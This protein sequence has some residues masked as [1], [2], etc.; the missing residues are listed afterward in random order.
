[1]CFLGLASD[2]DF[3]G[4]TPGRFLATEKSGEAMEFFVRL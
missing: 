1:M 4:S 3:Y 2:S